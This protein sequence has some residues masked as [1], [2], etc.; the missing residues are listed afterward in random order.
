M[1]TATGGGMAAVI[2]LTEEAI[3]RI[4]ADHRLD[5]LDVAN[6]NTPTQIALSGLMEDAG[7]QRDF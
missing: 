4:L 1:N 7:R 6:L 5:K 2:G 3:H